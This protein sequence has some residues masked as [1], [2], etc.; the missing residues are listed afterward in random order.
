MAIIFN[1]LSPEDLKKIGEYLEKKIRLTKTSKIIVLGISFLSISL[2]AFLLSSTATEN[3]HIR[4]YQLISEYGFTSAKIFLGLHFL[5]LLVLI[6]PRFPDKFQFAALFSLINIP[7]LFLI[8]Y[9]L[10][11]KITQSPNTVNESIIC[12]FMLMFCWIAF[13]LE[14][15]K[16]KPRLFIFKILTG[17]NDKI[18]YFYD[19]Y[20][21]IDYKKA[22]SKFKTKR[23][24]KG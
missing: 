15:Y 4:G 2:L 1:P 22:I 17:F 20:A 10:E 24:N 18:Q 11:R 7:L 19:E 23:K 8:Y 6:V 14:T 3:G 9:E 12:F 21:M 5:T 13:G 16:T